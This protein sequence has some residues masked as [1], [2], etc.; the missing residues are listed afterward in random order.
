MPGILPPFDTANVQQVQDVS[1]ELPDAERQPGDL[2]TRPG[3]ARYAN[4]LIALSEVTPNGAISIQSPVNGSLRL[5]TLDIGTIGITTLFEIAP[6]PFYIESILQKIHGGVP[7]F[8][9]GIPTADQSPFDDDDFVFEGQLLGNTSDPFYF[10]A[11]FQDRLCLEPWSWAGIIAQ[12]LDDAEID[13]TPWITFINALYPPGNDRTLKI[14]DHVGRPMPSTTFQI[15]VNG[16]TQTIISSNDGFLD[17]SSTAGQ[18]IQLQWNG[19]VDPAADTPLPVLSLYETGA[20]ADPESVLD[21]PDT[22]T[23]G[24]LQ[25]LELANWFAPTVSTSEMK[26]FHTKSRVEP[27][28]DGIETFRLI[29]QDMLACVPNSPIDIPDPPDPNNPPD[30]PG[31]HF[32]GWAFTEVEMDKNLLDSEGK[33]Y[34]FSNLIRHLTSVEGN[35]ADVRILVNKLVDIPGDFDNEVQ[36]NALLLTIIITDVILLASLA[37]VVSSNSTGKVITLLPQ[38]LAPIGLL[39]IED[40]NRKIEDS[41]DPSKDLFPVLNEIKE[42]IAIR[43][44]HPVLNQDNPLFQPI[45]L[46][47]P[48][49]VL[50]PMT[51]T[52][53]IPG[54][55]TWHQKIQLFKRASGRPDE[56]GNQFIGYLGGVDI[57]KNRV[58][59]FGHQ[60]SG[61]YHDVHA[62]LTGPGVADLFKSWDERYLRDKDQPSAPDGALDPIFP[63]PAANDLPEDTDAKHIL[64]IGRTLFKP[65][66]PGSAHELSFAP[67]GDQS[68]NDNM[69]RAIQQASEYIYIEDQYF[70][71]NE[72]T[73]PDAPPGY[74]DSLM[75]AAD[76]CKRLIVLVPS[77]LALGEMPFGQVR[78][79][80]LIRRLQT[81]WG[82]RVLI[83]APL[84]R[85]FLP[86]SGR[87]TLEGRCTLFEDIGPGDT[88]LKIGPKARLPQAIPFWLW[89]NGEL[90]FAHKIADNDELIDDRPVVNV[91]V[92]RG[93][94]LGNPR[95][96]AYARDHVKDSPVTA[97]QLK[98]IFVHAKIMM[99]DDIHVT[100]GSANLNRRGLFY[101]GEIGVFSVPEQLK[102]APDNPARALRTK[103]WAEQ[104]GLPPAMGPVLLQD[105]IA[106]FDLF[107]RHFYA[108][109][110]FMPLNYFDINEDAELEFSISDNLLA[111]ALLNMGLSWF[112][113]H[114]DELWNTFVDPT[115]TA[116]PDPT[117]GP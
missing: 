87:M 54:A 86:T 99:V 116:D 23:R 93:P 110:R 72:A 76:H 112:V 20:S 96:G 38:L 70:V 34:T 62:R 80:N 56:R 33:P 75:E 47:L 57:N 12:A 6:L 7:T 53:F 49:P 101:D 84:R 89:I 117:D 74:F 104:L 19:L 68:I 59:N 97:S 73:D 103:L 82:D 46:S 60:G 14:L 22:F 79:A 27:L 21:L 95:W 16:Q 107:H 26:R 11:L 100:I 25:V 91:E 4:S 51:L 64:Q 58:D 102:A 9:F 98:G 28:V 115:T 66:T 41:M 1:I 71:P 18:A 108:G 37:G 31:A 77:I 78:R 10:G 32:A 111:N 24:H 67:D 52:D 30:L 55:G 81:R 61:P 48:A 114:R 13:N 69:I 15:E 45:I 85:P 44:I 113:S 88:I 3:I 17:L 29:A 63:P 35:G 83:G 2:L 50:E 109:N 94:G 36:H 106:A 40:L 65:A 105:P 5:V 92:I 90:M 43:S 42:N 8:Y 39:F